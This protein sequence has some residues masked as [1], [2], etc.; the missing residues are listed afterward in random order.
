MN[1]NL[2]KKSARGYSAISLEDE[3]FNYQRVIFFTHEVNAETSQQLISQLL[4]LE[5]LN[6]G[7]PILMMINSPG[8]S[9]SDGLAIVD[10]MRSITS[11]VYTS[12]IGQASSMG[13]VLLAA[14]EK[15]H[16]TVSE[17]SKVMI[18]EPLISGGMG[19]SA[20]S[21]QRTA[22][23]ILETKRTINSLLAEF[24]GKDIKAVNKATSFDNYMSAAEAVEF[25]L[26]DSISASLDFKGFKNSER[27]DTTEL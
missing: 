3:M 11:P 9:C 6:P 5:T 26:A 10:V 1:V 7:E 17:H 12:V 20:T 18:H 15:G 25:G 2:I 19:G 22:E 24:T 21:I 16:R 14:G 8:G 4:T 27:K 13:A 23:S